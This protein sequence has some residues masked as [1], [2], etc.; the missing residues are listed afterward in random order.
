M[1]EINT[2]GPAFPYE[3]N[4]MTHP[5]L[6]KREYFAAKSMATELAVFPNMPAKEIA[7]RAFEVAD[8]MLKAREL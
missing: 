6:T 7:R 5:G 3:S 2:G 1:S 8:E 4:S